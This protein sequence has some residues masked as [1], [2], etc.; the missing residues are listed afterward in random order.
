[1]HAGGASRTER[2]LILPPADEA[3]LGQ[4]ID[5]FRDRVDYSIQNL[6]EPPKNFLAKLQQT[7][8]EHQQAFVRTSNDQRDVDTVLGWVTT[9]QAKPPAVI[10]AQLQ[11]DEARTEGEANQ[12]RA[13]NSEQVQEQEQEQVRQN[14]SFEREWVTTAAAEAHIFGSFF[15]FAFPSCH[16]SKSRSRQVAEATS[17][18]VRGL[19]C[20]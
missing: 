17:V 2:N 19:E 11:V 15:C 6:I 1:M 12:D 3:Q 16:R 4:A 20:Q 18:C 10:D 7:V 8:R 5:V 14:S 13:F 9:A